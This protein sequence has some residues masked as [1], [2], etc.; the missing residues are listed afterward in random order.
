MK[1]RVET[2]HLVHGQWH[3]GAFGLSYPQ[4]AHGG[5]W[6]AEAHGCAA[7]VVQLKLGSNLTGSAR[8]GGA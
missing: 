6:S 8:E 1:F 5:H 7:P 3:D 2:R 4:A